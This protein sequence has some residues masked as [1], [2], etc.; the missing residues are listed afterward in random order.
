MVTIVL[1]CHSKKRPRSGSSNGFLTDPMTVDGRQGT[2]LML[3][4]TLIGYTLLDLYY[5]DEHD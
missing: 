1:K 3:C 5:S 4:G 2:I